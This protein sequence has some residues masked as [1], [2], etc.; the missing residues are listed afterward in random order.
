MTVIA[1]DRVIRQDE[2]PMGIEY[3]K[4][5]QDIALLSSFLDSKYRIE[6]ALRQLTTSITMSH[7]DIDAHFALEAQGYL[8]IGRHASAPLLIH[9]YSQSAQY[10]RH[11]VAETLMCRGLI[12]DLDGKVIAR[13]FGKFFNL[14]EHIGLMGPVPEE[15]FEVYEKMDGSLGII[16]HWE[17]V[18][19]IAT[20]GSFESE[21]AVRASHILRKKYGHAKL[22]P[23]HT[24]LV[25]IIYPENRI[26]VDY[27]GLEDLVLL[28]ILHTESGEEVALHDVGLPLVKRYDGLKD[29]DALKAVQEDNKEGF[30]VRF[31]SGLRVKVKF[32]EYVRLHRI[33]TGVNA[34][35]VWEALKE[36]DDLEKFLESVP[37]EFYKWVRSVEKDLRAQFA[38]I[39]ADCRLEFRHF[40]NRKGAAEYYL[41]QC[42]YPAI[43]FRM[44]DGKNYDEIIWKMIRPE[45]QKAFALDEN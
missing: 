21:Q 30:V 7:I 12:T 34:R 31:K 1:L 27:A 16:F 38:E 8:Q 44:L 23:A 29:L 26:V 28:A 6:L 15:A 39:D 36:G 10:E 22:D 13:P 3:V 25:E 43:M 24:Y 4:S 32:D 20:R 40:D 45:H 17:G 37:D 5:K 41:G 33:L 2:F 35:T 9:N 42:K 19:Q 18:P 14:D 11:W